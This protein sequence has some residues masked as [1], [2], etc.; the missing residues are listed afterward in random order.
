[1]NMIRNQKSELN[2]LGDVYA[3]GIKELLD[4]LEIYNK[5]MKQVNQ[6]Y[7]IYSKKDIVIVSTTSSISTS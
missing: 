4:L 1:M 2:E 6:L 3:I 7:S 5:Q